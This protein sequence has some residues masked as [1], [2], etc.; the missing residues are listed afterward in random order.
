MEFKDY[1]TIAFSFA[2][3]IISIV[4]NFIQKN[5]ETERQIRKNLSET[6]EGIVKVNMESTFLK[7]DATIYNSENSLELR[8]LY[9]TQRRILIVHADYL[10]KRYDHL[11]TDIDCNIIANAFSF[12]SDYVKADDYWKKTIEKSNSNAMRH[13]NLR[14]YARFLY[15]QGKK[16]VGRAKYNEALQVEL[17]NTDGNRREK[18]DTY[19]TWAKTERDFNNPEEA[20][21]LL[22]E[23]KISCS[24]ISQRKM[25][26]DM[27]EQIRLATPSIGN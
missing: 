9:N 18:T 4:S 16:E 25:R 21:R 26:E 27:E 2:A 19:I 24:Q 15:M 10:A 6:L 5:K 8:R 12:I 3:L 14:G 7:R 20:G 17:E 11:L 13:M 23:A 22:E 1:L